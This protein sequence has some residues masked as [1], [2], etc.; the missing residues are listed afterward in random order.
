MA[1]DGSNKYEFKFKV[2]D[3]VVQNESEYWFEVGKILDMD[4]GDVA[5]YVTDN[6]S[7]SEKINYTRE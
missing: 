1:K 6:I 7:Y 5:T 3:E 4:L 2:A